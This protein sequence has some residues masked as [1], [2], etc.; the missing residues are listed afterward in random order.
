MNDEI[1]LLQ[2]DLNLQDREKIELLTKVE[3]ART[4]VKKL[5]IKFEEEYLEDAERQ[6][7]ESK[8]QTNKIKEQ[9]ILKRMKDMMRRCIAIMKA[10]SSK[11]KNKAFN[12][13]KMNCLKGAMVDIENRVSG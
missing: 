13:W 1:D 2:N 7:R 6:I 12:I 8:E 4:V 10:K 11:G 9:L 3:K 5:E